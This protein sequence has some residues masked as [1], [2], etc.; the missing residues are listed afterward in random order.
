MMGWPEQ[1]RFQV[2]VP[3]STFERGTRTWNQN[4]EPG[5]RNANLLSALLSPLQHFPATRFHLLF[6]LCD[7]LLLIGRQH[8]E[9]FRLHLR[10]CEGELGLRIAD[11]DAQRLQIAQVT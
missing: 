9:D 6:A 10:L 1:H 11:L 2:P 8:V 5:T 4:A 7:F 3:S